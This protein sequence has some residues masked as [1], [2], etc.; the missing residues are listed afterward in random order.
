MKKMIIFTDLDGTLLDYSTYSFDEALP[1]LQALREMDIPLIICSSKTAAEIKYYRKKLDNRHPFISEN[2]GGIFIPKTYFNSGIRNFLLDSPQRVRSG[3]DESPK[4][5]N[6]EIIEEDGYLVIRLGAMYADLRR[7]LEV[8][9]REGF[10]VKGFG[11]MTVHEVAEIGH[12]SMAEAEMAKE[13]DFDEPFIFE[14]NQEE[15]QRLFKA[16]KS[17]GF[18]YTKGM[19]FHILGN[20]DKGKAVSIVINLYTRQFGEITT[21]AIGDNYNDIPMM[22][23]VD[24]PILVQGPDKTYAVSGDIANLRR[25]EGIGPAGWNIGIIDLL[26]EIGDGH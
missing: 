26:K 9:R 15:T 10:A 21:V 1:A 2:G 7:T 16:I 8:L 6:F 20:S 13:R 3:A 24:Y 12:M 17:R 5:T 11:D 25:I 19:F 22:K 23:E 4:V 18:Y 14:G